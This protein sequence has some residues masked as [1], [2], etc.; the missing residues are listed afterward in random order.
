MCACGTARMGWGLEA[1]I[2]EMKTQIQKPTETSNNRRESLEDKRG[3]AGPKKYPKFHEN[4]DIV[5]KKNQPRNKLLHN[6]D[7]TLLA[8]ALLQ[9]S[10]WVVWVT[11]YGY[12]L[13][14]TWTHKFLSKE[15][16]SPRPDLWKQLR[17]KKL[18]KKKSLPHPIIIII[19][20]KEQRETH[21]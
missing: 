7:S 5:K 10:A 14:W 4:T 9:R 13:G 19:I 2:P 8:R 12:S 20:M 6:K 16:E 18:K 15:L 3:T 17:F 11:G 1:I 21:T